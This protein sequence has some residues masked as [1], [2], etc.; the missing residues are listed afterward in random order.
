MSLG[1]IYGVLDS[2]TASQHADEQRERSCANCRHQDASAGRYYE[3]CTRTHRK[4][5]AAFCA[6]ERM[7]SGLCGPHARLFEPKEVL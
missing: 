3:R 7:V 5:Y 6:S 2:V 1:S 4:P